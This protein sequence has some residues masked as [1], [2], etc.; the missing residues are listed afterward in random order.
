MHFA[1]GVVDLQGRAAGDARLAH[2]ARH[3]RRVRGH[4]AA[5]GE[6][7]LRGDHAVKVLRAR[8][9]AH[10]DDRFARLPALLRLIGVEDNLAGRR[11]GRGGQAGRQHLHARGG[12][13]RRVQ[14]LIELRRFDAVDRFALVDEALVRH[15][16]GDLHRRRPGALAAARLEHEEFA[17]LDGEFEVLHVAVMQLQALRDANELRVRLAQQRVVAHLGDGL[18]RA[19]TR[20]DILALRVRQ[21]FAE[22]AALAGV[23]VAGEADARR[24]VVTEVAVDHRLHIDGGAE[25]VRDVVL[26][27]IT[28]R[29]RVVP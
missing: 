16:H 4:A 11:A 27:A 1:L 12:V 26:T 22:Q 10:K 24:A 13:D 5:S 7:A 21:V 2:A 18:R 19:H 14:H 6:D 28:D 3:D 29:A 9:D 8:L 23:R 20:D 17:V 15:L 25:I